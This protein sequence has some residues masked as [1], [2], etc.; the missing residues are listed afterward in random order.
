MYFSRQ[1][2]LEEG[3]LSSGQFND[4]LEALLDWLVKVEPSLAEDQP[5]HGDLNTVTGF[6]DSHKVHLASDPPE[7]CHLTVKKLPKT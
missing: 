6:L 7:N 3:L 5:V 4:A 2:K 1:R